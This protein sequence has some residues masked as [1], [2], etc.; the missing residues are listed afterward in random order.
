MILDVALQRLLNNYRE[1]IFAHAYLV[2]TNNIDLALNDIKKFIKIIS[3]DDTYQDECNK[4]NICHLIDD[5]ALPSLITIIPDGK[6]IKKENIE[7]IKSSFALKPIYTKNNIYIIVKPELMN[8][9][10]Y[11]KMLKFIE[12]PEDNIIGFF[13]SSNKDKIA[14]TILSRLE[15]IRLFYKETNSSGDECLDSSIIDKIDDISKN[16]I[17]KFNNKDVKLLWYN[18]NVIKKEL[19]ERAH[20]IYLFRSMLNYYE[21]SLKSETSK[22]NA[23]KCKLIIK[24]LEM[25]NYNVNISL[26]L[27]SFF[28]ER[29][30]IYD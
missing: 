15:S 9:T 24:Y 13:I 30:Q 6:V 18:E 8:D 22:S 28:V 10:A 26:L 4:C 27:D 7:V 25:L 19:T 16:I 14:P 12:E 1:N 11:N 23:K 29:E 17:D 20:I 3:C 5:N 21:S 2:E